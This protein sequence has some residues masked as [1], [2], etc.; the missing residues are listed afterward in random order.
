MRPVAGVVIASLSVV[1]ILGAKKPFVVEVRSSRAVAAGPVVPM[2]TL[3]LR[4]SI[5]RVVESKES[6]LAPPVRVKFVSL[7]NVQAPE[8][9]VTASAMLSPIVVVPVDDSVVNAPV[10]GVV[11]PIVPGVTQVPPINEEALIVPVEA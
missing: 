4:A 9:T 8:L 1:V 7:A 10:F 2:P 3:L 5:E 6:P 11:D